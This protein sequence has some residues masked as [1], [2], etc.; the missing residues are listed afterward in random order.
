MQLLLTHVLITSCFF[1]AYSQYP[2]TWLLN[3]K[4]LLWKLIRDRCL[5]KEEIK[6]DDF[7]GE[8]SF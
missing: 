3:C 8:V 4:Q 2:V 1:S 6:L 5:N 7:T